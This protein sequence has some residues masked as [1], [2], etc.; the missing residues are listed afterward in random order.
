MK[1]PSDTGISIAYL[2]GGGRRIYFA[3][4]RNYWPALGPAFTTILFSGMAIL[5]WRTPLPSLFSISAGAVGFIAALVLLRSL[6]GSTTIIAQRDLL[7]IRNSL[8]LIRTPY[9][10]DIKQVQ[11]IQAKVA[12][13]IFDQP[14]YR[15]TTIFIGKLPYT[16]RA[17]IASKRDAEWIANEIKGAIGLSAER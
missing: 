4:M 15:L 5:F 13:Q 17:V 10:F 8:A 14:Y 1:R 2:P 3:P 11:D 6:F 12:F 9:R 16:V 7:T